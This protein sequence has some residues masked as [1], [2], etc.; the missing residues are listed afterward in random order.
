MEHLYTKVFY[1]KGLAEGM[2]IKEESKEGKLLLHIIDT[3]EDFAYAINET[4]ENN[5]DLEEYV[6]FIDEDLFEVE[7]EL[8]GFEDEFCDYDDFEDD[9]FECVEL[10]CCDDEA[11]EIIDDEK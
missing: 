10:D 4:M 8:Y 2:E 11:K 9:I 6:N 1:L 5:E 3:L 7:D